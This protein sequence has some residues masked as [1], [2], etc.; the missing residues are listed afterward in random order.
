MNESTAHLV[1]IKK[2]IAFPES[3]SKMTMPYIDL[4]MYGRERMIPRA[5]VS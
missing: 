5:L 1:Y 4:T 2:D 3:T